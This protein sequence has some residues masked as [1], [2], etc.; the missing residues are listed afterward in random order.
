ML[1]IFAKDYQTL[2][3]GGK[4]KKTSIHGNGKILKPSQTIHKI[5]I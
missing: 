4:I 2:D 3:S 1:L 5:V